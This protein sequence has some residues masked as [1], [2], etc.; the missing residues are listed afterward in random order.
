[1]QELTEQT[2]RILAQRKLLLRETDCLE[3]S[4]TILDSCC[5]SK[6]V[7][8]MTNSLPYSAQVETKQFN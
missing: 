4:T 2:K 3:R 1:M 8:P 5:K 7:G 6:N